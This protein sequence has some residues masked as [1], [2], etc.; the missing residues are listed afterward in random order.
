MPEMFEVV[1]EDGRVQYVSGEVLG[2][3]MGYDDDDDDDDY[4]SGPKRRR[5]GRRARVQVERAAWRDRQLAP[6]VQA[7]DQG[8]YPLGLAPDNATGEFDA[9]TAQ[10]I[11]TGRLQKPFRA[12]RVL[13]RVVRTG[14]TATGTLL[15]QIFVGTDLQQAS[16]RGVNVENIGDPNAFG[17]RT[18]M[19]PAQP[20]VDISFV[21]RPTVVPGGTDTIVLDMELIGRIV[22]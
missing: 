10:I 5:R 20:G 8:M 9:T 7:P 4:V 16:I 19:A 11:F 14:A 21:V 6:G 18:T 12:E 15:A 17:V 3:I 13:A 2:A 22:A 1:G